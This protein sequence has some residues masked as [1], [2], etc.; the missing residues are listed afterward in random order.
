MLSEIRST[1]PDGC[2]SDLRFDEWRASELDADESSV[3]AAHVDI[4]PRCKARHEELESAAVA[5]L[6]RYPLP[7]MRVSDAKAVES[8][9]RFPFGLSRSVWVPVMASAS[10]LL[11]LLFFTTRD[12]NDDTG[13]RS[14]GGAS[15]GFVVKRSAQL[16]PGSSGMQV[17]PGDQLR[18]FVSGASH[19]HV[20]VLSKDARGIVSEYYPGT[21]QSGTVVAGPR[22]FLDS[23]VELDA[24]LGP[25]TIWAVLCTEAFSTGPL[26]EELE[27]TNDLGE[28]AGCAVERLE[29]V[30]RERVEP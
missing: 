5:F 14:K 23:S 1:I 20:A 29:L 24:T 7:P 16:L 11:V 25:E 28:R 3:V 19:P 26:L 10:L 4:C 18:F 6:P 21:G 22:A 9:W 12:P 27:R 13:T 17:Q 8:P 2:V 15:V 30:K